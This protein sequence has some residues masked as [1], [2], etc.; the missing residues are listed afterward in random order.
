M[1]AT[2]T[3]NKIALNSNIPK[4]QIN[5]LLSSMNELVGYETFDQSL[6]KH[7]KINSI[8]SDA[9]RLEFLGKSSVKILANKRNQQPKAPTKYDTGM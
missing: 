5:K 8:Q 2:P 1:E 4:V 3:T 9:S 7:L 6:Q